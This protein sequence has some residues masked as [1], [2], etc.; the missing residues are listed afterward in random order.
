MG[1][2][3]DRHNTVDESSIDEHRL[4]DDEEHHVDRF[5]LPTVPENCGPQTVSLAYLLELAINHTN[6]DFQILSEALQK[7]SEVERKVAILNFATSTRVVFL[8]IYALVKWLKGSRRFDQLSN[9]CFFL[10]QLSDFYVDTA[11]SFVQVAREELV[12]AR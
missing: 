7:K 4:F 11:D 10:D 2:L 6:R 3:T 1:V 9:I 8:K 12:F 5:L